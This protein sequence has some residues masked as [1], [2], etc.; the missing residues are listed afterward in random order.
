MKQLYLRPHLGLGDHIICNGMVRY[1]AE[2]YVIKMPCKKHNVSSVAY[3]FSDLPNVEL[4]P[5]DNDYM[6]NSWASF[7]S[8]KGWNVLMLGEYGRNFRL[9]EGHF[10]EIFY[11][12]ANISYAT[13]WEK[14]KV[15]R[16]LEGEQKFYQDFYGFKGDFTFVHEDGKR[17]Y[18]LR[19]ELLNSSLPVVR[20]DQS[21]T[22]N[23]F[24][25]CWI[26][27][28]ATQIDCLDSS[29]SNLA[30]LLSLKAIVKRIHM[31]ARPDTVLPLH[32]QKWEY[33]K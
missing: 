13:K 4:I 27:E 23:I 18:L 28:N 14:F 6:A 26:L 24:D 19:K 3:M 10:D 30:D 1:F 12:Q 9:S 29:F 16:R 31:Y 25:Y 5:V 22:N 17:K 8:A 2:T 21:F 20:P 7:W 15:P 32:R 11:R 33:V